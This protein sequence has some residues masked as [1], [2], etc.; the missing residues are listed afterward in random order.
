MVQGSLVFP[1]ARLLAA[2][3]PHQ[4]AWRDQA[5]LE[6]GCGTGLVGLTAARLGATVCKANKH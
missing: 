6:L 5:V 4:S 1:A 3:L 2:W